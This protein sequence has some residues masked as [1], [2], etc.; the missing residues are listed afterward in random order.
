M[1]GGKASL[2]VRFWRMVDTA[3]PVPAARPELG[4]CWTWTGTTQPDGYGKISGDRGGRRATMRAHRV[5]WEL[6]LGPIPRGVFVLH[7]CDTPRCVNPGHLF[8]GTAADNSRDM[9]AKGRSLRGDRC[10]ARA[11]PERLRRGERHRWAK[12]TAREVGV[13]RSLRRRGLTY[14]AIADRLGRRYGTVYDAVT[15]RNWR[16]LG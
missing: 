4:P 7:R 12:L 3:G 6:H 15:G 1:T 8:L 2:A 9:V 16:S 11:H 14:R 5:S 13:A 10:P